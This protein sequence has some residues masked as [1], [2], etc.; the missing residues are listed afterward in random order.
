MLCALP[1]EPPAPCSGAMGLKAELP[2]LLKADSCPLASGSGAAEA[3]PAVPR[4]PTQK[5][6]SM[7]P[8]SIQHHSMQFVTLTRC[9]L[10]E[11]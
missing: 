11:G 10:I 2:P 1:T 7:F 9:L 3:V 6:E 5:E 8:H 4:S